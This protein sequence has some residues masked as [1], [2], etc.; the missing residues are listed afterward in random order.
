MSEKER[1]IVDHEKLDDFLGIGTEEVSK[2]EMPSLPSVPKISKD[3]KD[4]DGIYHEL[5][6]LIDTSKEILQTAKYLIDTDPKGDAING[7]ASLIN[8]VRGVVGE[9]TVLYRDNIRYTKQKEL[10]EY[11]FECKKDIIKY[12][13]DIDNMKD[14]TET[15]PLTEFSQERVIK[16]ILN[17]NI[18]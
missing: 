15:I 6:S 3:L 18:I 12:K 2:P 13:K 4:V 5:K 1:F 14:V 8:A 11:K 16:D 17:F 10:E 7:V 9:F